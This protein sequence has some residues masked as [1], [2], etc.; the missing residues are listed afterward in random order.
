MSV[1]SFDGML[2]PESQEG[3]NDTERRKNEP[4]FSQWGAEVLLKTTSLG[5]GPF[6][7]FFINARVL[8][9]GV[10]SISLE[11]AKQGL[12]AN[13]PAIVAGHEVRFDERRQCSYADVHLPAAAQSF[14]PW[15]RM[16]LVRFQPDSIPGCHVSPV[17]LTSFCQLLPNRMVTA[18]RSGVDSRRLIISVAG[19]GPTAQS[20]SA[21]SVKSVLEVKALIPLDHQKADVKEAYLDDEGKLWLSQASAV[22]PWAAGEDGNGSYSGELW[23]AKPM[24]GKT[25]LLLRESVKSASDQSVF[26]G[27]PVLLD[28]IVL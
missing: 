23:V 27:R 1:Q 3:L 8:F 24:S 9:D 15:L 10:N 11:E 12:K 26:E 7:H 19:I 20:E 25:R 28:G 13:R 5:D 2:P 17:V 16:G 21:D 4:Y 14:L 6:G 22:L 18:I